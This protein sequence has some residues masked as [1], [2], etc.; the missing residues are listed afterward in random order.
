MYVQSDLLR[1]ELN[2]GYKLHSIDTMSGINSKHLKAGDPQPKTSS[3][4]LTLF[5]MRFCPY[6]QRAMLVALKKNLDF[7]TIN[8]NLTKKPEWYESINPL[9][10]VPSVQKGDFMA[11]ESMVVA[12]YLDDKYPETRLTPDTPEQKAQDNAFVAAHGAKVRK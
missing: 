9:M 4:R 7:D 2:V 6:A 8:I 11:Y 12:E 1:A 5:N 3:G 10:K